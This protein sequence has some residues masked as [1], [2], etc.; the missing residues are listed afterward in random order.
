LLF[1]QN[2][3]RLKLKCG[4]CLVRSD[5]NSSALRELLEDI[6]PLFDSA[7]IFK[8]SR[9]T[10]AGITKIVDIP[11]LNG[12]EVFVK[13][14]NNK[15]HLYTFRYIF[16]EPR[17][18]RV[19][20]SAFALATAGVPTPRPIAAVAVYSGIIPENAFLLRESIPEVIPTLELFTKMLSDER[21]KTSYI[22]FACELF[23]KAHNAGIF[24][25]DAKCSN[26]YAEPN[27]DA[28]P[29]GCSLGLWDLL[30]C[31]VTS[32]PVSEQMRIKE[33]RRLSDSFAEIARRLGHT[34]N[35]DETFNIFWKQYTKTT[36]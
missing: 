25:G 9:T 33:I 12:A 10:K 21:A 1:Y 14:F 5:L 8:D 26:I 19:W 16:R 23:V 11:Y 13:R 35:S 17:P 2:A 3:E 6:D 18:F 29:L 15:G 27:T 4:K 30:S 31:Q 34:F 28:G 7:K 36:D 24:H 22:K 32:A 20:R